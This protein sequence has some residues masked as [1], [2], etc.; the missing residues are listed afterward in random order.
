MRMF[1]DQCYNACFHLVVVLFKE[2]LKETFLF[3]FLGDYKTVGVQ[4]ICCKREGQSLLFLFF[5]VP[6]GSHMLT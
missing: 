6:H 3:T 4:I 1:E 2:P 5:G